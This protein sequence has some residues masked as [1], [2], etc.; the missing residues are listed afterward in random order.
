M[1]KYDKQIRLVIEKNVD[2]QYDI[3]TIGVLDILTDYGI[4]SLKYI[5]IIIALEDYF[6]IKIPDNY[7]DFSKSNTIQK[8]NLILEKLL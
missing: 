8:L 2:L 6:D 3:N 7:L 4:D 5:S 1:L